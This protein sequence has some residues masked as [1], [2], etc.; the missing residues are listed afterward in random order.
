MKSL[1]RSRGIGDLDDLVGRTT[2]VQG[3]DGIPTH[4][5]GSG[6]PI[7]I[8]SGEL[9]R[10]KRQTG[11]EVLGQDLQS[12][13]GIG[14]ADPDLHVE[15]PRPQDGG[16]DH[17]L[18]VGCS[19]DDNV[20]QGLHAVDLCQD[21]RDD[22]GFNIRRHPGATSAEK[23]LHLIEEDDD[24]PVLGRDL[25]SLIEDGTYLALGFPDELAEQ[26]RALD[27]QEC[28]GGPAPIRA[29]VRGE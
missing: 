14:A 16:V 11:S 15:S 7:A 6:L 24:G 27:V 17:V 21:L 25:A 2:V 1:L 10:V 3:V 20:A 29:A 9:D 28:G 12:T 8:G 26:L 13:S 4:G 18:P 23:S 22:H 5:Q 19:D